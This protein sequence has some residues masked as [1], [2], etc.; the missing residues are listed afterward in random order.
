MRSNERFSLIEV[1][2]ETGRT[3]QIRVHMAGIGCP[4]VGDKLYGADERL[5]LQGIAGELSQADRDALILDRHAL[6]S[7]SLT[8]FHPRRDREVTIKAPLPHEFAE[9]VPQ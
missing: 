8:F 3:H 1:K 7:H 5:F 6:H 9:L 2:P 4:L